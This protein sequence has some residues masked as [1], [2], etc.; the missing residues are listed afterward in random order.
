MIN[1]KFAK[2]QAEEIT[3]NAVTSFVHGIQ[4]LVQYK[5][6]GRNI[7]F[8]IL[9][10]F[11]A[12]ELFVKAYLGQENKYLLQEKI[13]NEKLSDKAASITVLLQRMRIFSEVSVEKILEK[14]IEDL[15]GMRNDIE[16]KRFVLKDSS[17]TMKTLFDVVYG[18]RYFTKI[19]LYNELLENCGDKLIDELNTVRQE[20]F[21]EISRIIEKTD[22]FR[23][24]GIKIAKC[25]HCL[26]E[27]IPFETESIVDCLYCKR[28]IVVGR[29][30][31]CKKI[32]VWPYPEEGKGELLLCDE[33]FTHPYD[34][35][36]KIEK[37]CYITERDEYISNLPKKSYEL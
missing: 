29:C 36:N 4:H 28:M 20:I 37:D 19:H 35:E 26:I 16:H 12:V 10:V 15:R 8:A 30:D 24:K 27:T 23:Q 22:N 17:A 25:P 5:D 32:S 6:G 18:L 31:W 13:D 21:P 7:K 14:Q 3:K 2:E 34:E 33:C 11:N 9:H 1:N